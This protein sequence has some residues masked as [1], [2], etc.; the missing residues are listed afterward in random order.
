MY[1]WLFAEL[2]QQKN[3]FQNKRENINFPWFGSL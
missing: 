3:P 2:K 1:M